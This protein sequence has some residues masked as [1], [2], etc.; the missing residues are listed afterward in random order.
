MKED[1]AS[2]RGEHCG[3]SSCPKGEEPPCPN[4]EMINKEND[5]KKTLAGIAGLLMTGVLVVSGCAEG[6]TPLPYDSQ[7]H[8]DLDNAFV[9]ELFYRNDLFT[10][11]P[12]PCVIR[13]TD[14][15]ST[16]YGYYYLYGTSDPDMG[17]RAYR[18]KDLTGRWED[19]TPTYNFIAFQPSAGHY[20]YGKGAFWAPEVIYDADAGKYYMFYSGTVDSAQL[21][22]MIG[23]AV[24]D[25]PYGPF[26]PATDDGL[27][28][29][30]PLFDNDR[31]IEWC[32]ANGEETSGGYFNCIDPHPYV[33]PDGTKYLYFSHEHRLSGESSDI[34]GLEMETWTKPVYE[35]LTV[36]TRA[37]YDTVTK[38]NVP[39]Y[40]QG[41]KTNEG[42]WMYQ[43]QV[44]G[45]WKYYLTLS[46]NGYTD[47]S[48]TVIQAIGDSPLGPFR[49]LTEEEGGILLGTDGQRFDHVS[50]TGHHSFVEVDGEIWMVY[51][52]HLNRESGGT[53]E[54][55]VAIDKVVWTKNEDGLDVLYCNGP[56]WSLQPRIAKYSGYKNIAPEAQLKTNGGDNESALT[57]GML[58]IYS[59]ISYVKEYETDKDAVITLSF[60]DWREVTAIMIYNSKVFEHSFVNIKRIELDFEYE[61]QT[62]TAAIDELP[63]NWDFYKMSTSFSMRPGGS[64]VAVF[65]PLKVKEIRV[66][67]ELPKERPED[68]AIMDDEGNFIAQQ[69]VAVSEIVVLGK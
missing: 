63:F 16:E 24:A 12:D 69:K 19:V 30:T 2:L 23:V 49:K 38:D 8:P 22:R 13:I 32:S 57:D 61:G 39:E 20:A 9:E 25:E 17:F 48:Y 52:E 47:K 50:G 60:G 64:A 59:N 27:S 33:A 42:A 35:T 67:I 14:E 44:N 37:G 4:N 46:I 36:L 41:N 68:I 62:G 54:R 29:A 5:M 58:T 11:T 26:R 65:N 1:L 28:A 34:Y 7:I 66:E 40:E 18:N 6:T 43:K 10:A 56:T 51:H 21:H 55:D 3:G 31:M 45:K 15:E 53:G